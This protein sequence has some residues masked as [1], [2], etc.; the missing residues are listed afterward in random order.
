MA[1]N[2]V[3]TIKYKG[4]TTT[5]LKSTLNADNAL[6]ESL[7][8]GV[9][10]GRYRVSQLLMSEPGRGETILINGK[11]VF[12]TL[13]NRDPVDA[14]FTIDTQNQKPVEGI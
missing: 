3:V 4:E 13:V 2:A 9:T 8:V 10:T 1:P 6:G 7:Q 14:M 12:V 11:A 5:A